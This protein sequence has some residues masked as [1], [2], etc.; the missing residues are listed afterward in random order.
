MRLRF[1]QQQSEFRAYGHAVQADVSEQPYYHYYPRKSD[2]Q[3]SRSDRGNCAKIGACE[4]GWKAVCRD[5]KNNDDLLAE[6]CSPM[7]PED[8]YATICNEKK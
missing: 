1:S 7:I 6:I 5:R 8:V 2:V 4:T 3:C